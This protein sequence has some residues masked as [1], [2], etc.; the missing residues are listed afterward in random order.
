MN[1]VPHQM[2]DWFSSIPQDNCGKFYATIKSPYLPIYTEHFVPVWGQVCDGQPHKATVHTALLYN[3]FPNH[4]KGFTYV[5]WR[6]EPS[7]PELCK[8]P[9]SGK[10]ENPKPYSG[11]PHSED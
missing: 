11:K 5:S 7:N 4:G 2:A 9:R 6:T 10:I 1:D 3:K 8:Y